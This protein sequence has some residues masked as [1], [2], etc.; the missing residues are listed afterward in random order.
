MN[1]VLVIL[2]S[3]RRDHVGCYGNDW[4]RTP[5]LDALATESTRFTGFYPEALPTLQARRAIHTGNRVFPFTGHQSHK[6]DTVTAPGWGPIGEEQVSLAEI[7]GHAGYRTGLVTDVYHQMKPSMN[8]HRGFNQFNWIRGQEGDKYRSTRLPSADLVE[9]FLHPSYD[10]AAMAYRRT[11]LRQYL[12]NISD[13]RSEEDF[14][15]PQ[16]F[17]EAMR[18]VEDNYPED[19][20][21]V[22]DCF[23]PHEPWDPPAQYTELYDPGYS[24]R[25]ITWPPYGPVGGISEAELKHIRALYAGEV[26]MTDKWLGLFIDRLRDVNVLDDTLLI[27]MSDHGH[28]LG[29]H[30]VLGKI[31]RYQY[32]D[33]VDVIL[34]VRRPGAEGGGQVVPGF[35]YDHDILPT[36]LNFAGV[37]APLPVDGRDL[38]PLILGE[39]PGRPHITGGYV[40]YVRYQDNAHHYIARNDGADASLYHLAADPGMQ[41]NIAAAN[42]E[43]VADLHEKIRV[44]AGGS[45]PAIS[46]EDLRVAG[47]WHELNRPPYGVEP[48]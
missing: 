2:D 42:P 27:V 13:R 21:L 46:D 30:G 43:L 32:P 7:M 31:P 16:V 9:S 39:D 4:I 24:G 3:L 34:L 1:V 6:G 33:L 18:F 37:E 47:P 28:T 41:N 15:A 22:I 19:F 17:R 44:D 45:F 26:T 35:C 11:R 14:F 5:A 20:L 23:D 48:R 25:E 12:A 10:P 36:I 38:M 8:F 40:D 29:E